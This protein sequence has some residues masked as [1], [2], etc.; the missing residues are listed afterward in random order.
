MGQAGGGG[1]QK[2]RML[3]G[4]PVG[5]ARPIYPLQ[6]L[7]STRSS[8]PSV[9]ALTLGLRAILVYITSVLPP[10]PKNSN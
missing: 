7:G 3:S 8:S 4:Q 5:P 1:H 10:S 9:V 6:C 2:P